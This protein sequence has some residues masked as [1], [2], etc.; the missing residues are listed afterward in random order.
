MKYYIISLI[1]FLAYSFN[2]VAQQDSSA[3]QMQRK[4]INQLLAD[5]S[6]K[7]GRYDQSLSSRTGIFGLKTKKDMQR[8]NDILTEIVKTDNTV[9]I[10]LKTLLDYKDLEKTE[11]QDKYQ[12]TESSKI[13]FMTTITKLQ[14]QNDQLK[15]DLE[16]SKAQNATIIYSLLIFLLILTGAGSYLYRTKKLTFN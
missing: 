13:N 5:R 2:C 15:D 1:F 7:F 9:F 14:Q 3:Y 10:E 12:E 8:S 11:V 6:A 4:K 16:K